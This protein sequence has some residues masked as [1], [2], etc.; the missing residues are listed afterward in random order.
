[1]LAAD[2]QPGASLDRSPFLIRVDVSEP[3]DPG[4]FPRVPGSSVQLISNANGTLATAPTRS[5]TWPAQFNTDGTEPLRIAPAA[6][7]GPGYYKVVL[8][9]DTSANPRRYWPDLNGFPWNQF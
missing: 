3:L 7:L 9:G 8:A 1:V 6:P 4:T 2:P 5:S